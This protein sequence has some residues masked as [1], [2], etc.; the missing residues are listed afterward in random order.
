MKMPINNDT[1]AKFERLINQTLSDRLSTMARIAKDLFVE[2]KRLRR[3]NQK[4]ATHHDEVVKEYN[5]QLAER[6]LIIIDLRATINV[7]RKVE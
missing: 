2:V 7:L 1:M 4:L 6:D 3:E 5:Q